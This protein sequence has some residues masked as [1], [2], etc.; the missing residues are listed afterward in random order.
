MEIK[1]SSNNSSEKKNNKFNKSGNKSRLFFKFKIM[2]DNPKLSNYMGKYY[3]INL[4]PLLKK[5]FSV[6]KNKINI[7]NLPP[8]NLKQSNNFSQTISLSKSNKFF[9]NKEYKFCE[10]SESRI[11][12][13]NYV[14]LSTK[15]NNN[16]NTD[17][18]ANKNFISLTESNEYNKNNKKYTY[19]EIMKRINERYFV[20]K[21]TMKYLAELFYGPQELHDLKMINLKK[22]KGKNEKE[23]FNYKNKYQILD[24]NNVKD[25]NKIMNNK[26][27]NSFYDKNKEKSFDHYKLN[28]EDMLYLKF[29][30][31]K[32]L[33]INAVDNLMKTKKNNQKYFENLRKTCDFKYENLDIIKYLD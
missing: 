25:S 27:I 18:F 26:I 10:D 22:I 24:K 19:E 4:N 30:K 8:I 6:K 16:I 2:D 7:K 28:Y 29:K 15:K 21:S 17:K 1:S 20:R 11:I 13:K 5:N 33:L 14:S 31:N 3:L 23:I 9:D 32:N 12:P